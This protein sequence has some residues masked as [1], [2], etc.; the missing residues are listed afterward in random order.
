MQEKEELKKM[1]EDLKNFKISEFG[2][3]PNEND[4][5]LLDEIYEKASKHS[6]DIPVYTDN[7]NEK[8]QSVKKK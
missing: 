2:D 3:N 8:E 7:T 4:I 5:D 1:Y 6:T